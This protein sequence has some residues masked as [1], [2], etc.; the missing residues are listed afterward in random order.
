MGG[1]FCG[2]PEAAVRAVPPDL[3]RTKEPVDPQQVLGTNPVTA[4]AT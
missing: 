2:S 3:A 4:N 1:I